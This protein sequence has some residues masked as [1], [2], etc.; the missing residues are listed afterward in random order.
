MQIVDVTVERA[1][2]EGG[3]SE[4]PCGTPGRADCCARAIDDAESPIRPN[5][6]MSVQAIKP[7][8]FVSQLVS[9]F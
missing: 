8:A 4:F 2:F 1:R 7:Y 5:R 3:S 9:V 6:R